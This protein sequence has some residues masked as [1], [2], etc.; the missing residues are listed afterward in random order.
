MLVVGGVQVASIF[1]AFGS[2]VQLFQS[3]WRILSSEDEDVSAVAAAFREA[4]IVVREGF[5]RV[6]SFET[7]RAGCG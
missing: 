2:Q 6:E 3:G 5:G 4:G 7:R 1:N